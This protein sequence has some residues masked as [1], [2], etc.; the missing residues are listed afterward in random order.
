MR[1]FSLGSLRSKS[2]SRERKKS[3]NDGYEN[4]DTKL[5]EL[6]RL[7]STTHPGHMRQL[8]GHS[9]LHM[10]F[11]HRRLDRLSCQIDCDEVYPNIIIG[12]E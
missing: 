4:A 2:A 3:I 12:D 6:Q 1:R 10:I 11:G 9:H 8:P 7:I 5:I